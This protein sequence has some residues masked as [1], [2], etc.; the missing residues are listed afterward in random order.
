M[1]ITF[2]EL[3]SIKHKLPTG[4]VSRIAETLEIDEQ[5]VRD[6]FGAND[7]TQGEHKQPGPNGGVIYLPDTTILDLAQDIIAEAER[8]A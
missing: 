6:Y 8:T 7:L 4:S 1:N 5:T 3:R 2:E